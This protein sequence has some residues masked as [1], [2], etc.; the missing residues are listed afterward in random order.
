MRLRIRCTPKQIGVVITSILW[1][2]T[3]R[4]WILVGAITVIGP[5]VIAIGAVLSESSNASS[6]LANLGTAMFLAIPLLLVERVLE[7]RLTEA[8]EETDRTLGNLDGRI[9]RVQQS[10]ADVSEQLAQVTQRTARLIDERRAAEEADRLAPARAIADEPSFAAVMN[11]L[12]AAERAKAIARWTNRGGSWVALSMSFR[13]RG[14]A[15]E[16]SLRDRSFRLPPEFPEQLIVTVSLRDSSLRPVSTLWK[17][18]MAVE[19]CFVE[20]DRALRRE[21]GSAAPEVPPYLVLPRL[22]GAVGLAL[23]KRTAAGA[24]NSWALIGVVTDTWLVSTTG[25]EHVLRGV[26][27]PA[28]QVRSADAQ[29]PDAP[30][31][32]PDRGEW[33]Y[34]WS[35]AQRLLARGKAILDSP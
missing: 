2:R 7:Q 33:P 28:A 12:K 1:R 15:V 16:I 23:R 14:Y 29:P 5:A 17:P 4:T 21:L 19:E 20:I 27:I 11:A 3:P 6:V 30:Q 9:G 31:D 24:T 18:E 10:V 32:L 22:A 34:A 26:V 13:D 8:R 25:L 35:E